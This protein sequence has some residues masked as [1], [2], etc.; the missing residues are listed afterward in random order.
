GRS[1]AVGGEVKRLR[2]V[3]D[4]LVA[5]QELLLVASADNT[6]HVYYITFG[7]NLSLRA[8]EIAYVTHEQGVNDIALIPGRPWIV[9][10]STDGTI[11]VWS[12]DSFLNDAR[13]KPPGTG[14]VTSISFQSKGTLLSG[15]MTGE[16]IKASLSEG[17]G[18]FSVEQL[19]QDNMIGSGLI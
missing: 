6:A 14:V 4:P 10:A 17:K 15:G 1:I 8:I 3:A 16:L 2:F 5:Q 9:T 18:N 13:L 11:R 7:E 12:I 19:M